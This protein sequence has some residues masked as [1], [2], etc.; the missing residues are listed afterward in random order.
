MRETTVSSRPGENARISHTE[1]AHRLLCA[2]N[3]YTC[4][5]PFRKETSSEL[6]FSCI[7]TATPH[8]ALSLSKLSDISII[9]GWQSDA[10]ALAQHKFGVS[11]RKTCRGTKVGGR[12]PASATPTTTAAIHST[13]DEHAMKTNTRK[14]KNGTQNLTG[15]VK[16]L[17]ISLRVNC[18]QIAALPHRRIQHV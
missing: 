12:A 15:K 10:F 8:N 9:T 14:N 4:Y 1:R 7:S 16:S 17:V 3:L 5:L 6:F 13:T 18:I 2:A 11:Q